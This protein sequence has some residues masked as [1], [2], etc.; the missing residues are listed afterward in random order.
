MQRDLA[1]ARCGAPLR[2]RGPG[3]ATPSPRPSAGPE[4]GTAVRLPRRRDRAPMRMSPSNRFGSGIASVASLPEIS[5]KP[6]RGSGESKLNSTTLRPAALRTRSARKRGWEPRPR[7]P[8]RRAARCRSRGSACRGGSPQRPASPGRIPWPARSGSR[9]PCRT[10]ARPALEQELRV[11]V[12]ALRSRALH[13]GQRGLRRP[14]RAGVDEP[15]GGLQAGA[16]HGVRRAADAHAGGVAAA[17]SSRGRRRIECERLLHPDALARRDRG[18]ATTACAAGTVR[19]TTIS[20]S[21][22]ASASASVPAPG[23]SRP[24][25]GPC[26]LDVEI[27]AEQHAQIGNEVR[28]RRY[29]VLMVPQPTTATPTGLADAHRAGRCPRAGVARPCSTSHSGC[30]R[31]PQH[32]GGASVKLDDVPLRRGAAARISATGIGPRRR[33]SSDLAW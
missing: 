29:A 15:A 3:R 24:P 25:P 13:Q 22:W 7:I 11:R 1:V 17:S 9:A 5:T 2:S 26:P 21:G 4:A 33:R 8:C 10:A 32:V 30:A 16:Q 19:L 12:P 20:T 23:T 31:R 28:L 14:D 6:C 27:G 18:V